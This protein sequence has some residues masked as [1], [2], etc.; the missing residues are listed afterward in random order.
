MNRIALLTALFTVNLL[1]GQTHLYVNGLLGND[2]NTGTSIT[3][4]WRT[5]QKA[6]NAATPGSIVH[7]TAGTY[8]ESL[9]PHVS[10]TST[11]RIAFIAD[12]PNTVFID[13]TGTNFACLLRVENRSY[14]HFENLIFQNLTKNAGNGVVVETLGQPS[15][16]AISFKNCIIRNIRWTANSNTEP[17]DSDN[18]HPF[19]AY[20]R[21]GGLTNLTVDGLEVYNNNT[22]YS[23]ALT[24]EGNISGFAI[25]NCTVRDNSN[26]GILISGQRGISDVNDAVRNGTVSGN[27]CYNNLSALSTSG[28]IYVDG[29]THVTIERNVSHTNGYGIEI[30][31]EEDVITHDI[32]VKN[33]I[34]YDNQG[35]G[36]EVGGYNDDTT[37]IVRDCIIRNNTFYKN[38]TMN[39]SVGELHITKVDNCVIQNN[40]F[41]TSAQRSLFSVEEITPQ[42]GISFRNNSWFSP[43][44]NPANA[45]VIWHHIEYNGFSTYQAA[46]GFDQYSTFGNPGLLSITGTLDFHLLANSACINQGD[47]GTIVTADEKDFDGNNRI[48]G[49]IIDRG[50]F[51]SGNVLSTQP[52]A[53]T[54][55]SLLP[56]PATNSVTLTLSAKADSGTVA[57]FDGQGR[58]VHTEN[59]NQLQTILD[60]SGL[61]EG[62]YFVNVNI[63]GERSVSKLL[64]RR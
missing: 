39:E 52:T 36:I 59:I 34:L 23:E 40:I 16:T 46:L 45:S 33:N 48:V 47:T 30:G 57:F 25:K 6:C 26:I 54:K 63:G 44:N 43:G 42:S 61:R 20:G 19:I 38:D 50:A 12:I 2:T 49:N 51:E 5:I 15:A 10:G 9:E 13:G 1:L 18:S 35:G 58:Q 8:T 24:L 4:P 27:L 17:D 22:G 29:G 11:N 62:I 14:L 41:Y 55:Y 32:T 64:I 56:N 53:L 7:I 3:N 60:V 28:G 37:G 21:H 31:A